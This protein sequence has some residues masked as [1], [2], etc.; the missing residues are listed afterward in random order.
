[1]S[2]TPPPLGSLYILVRVCLGPGLGL[3]T[4]LTS[5]TVFVLMIWTHRD[6]YGSCSM[7]LRL[8]MSLHV[9][10]HMSLHVRL[11]MSLHVHLHMS[12]ELHMSLY[13]HMS[14]HMSLRLSVRFSNIEGSSR[15]VAEVSVEVA[16]GAP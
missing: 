5:H 6:T 15:I 9:R 14:L 7:S 4:G 3:G 11:H 2:Y 10:L 1:M 13:L 8:H 12:L 16:V